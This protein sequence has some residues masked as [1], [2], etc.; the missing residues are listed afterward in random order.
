MYKGMYIALSGAMLKQTQLE[1]ITQNIANAN[2]TAYKKQGLSFRDYLLPRENA[3]S[4]PDGRIMVTLSQFATDFSNGTQVRT[5]NPFDIAL[6][7]KGMI[8][9]EGNRYTRRGDLMKD[10]EGYLT[11]K[12]GSKV[13]GGGGPIRIPESETGGQVQ[14]DPDGNIEVDGTQVDKIRIEEF[15][16]PEALTRAGDGAYASAAPGTPAA[17]V[18][19]QGYLETSNVSAVTEMIHMIEAMRE[20]ES[21]QKMIQAMDEAAAKVNNDLGRL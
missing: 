17:G 15:A 4:G 2:T 9:L 1:V 6:S 19:M 14:I 7:G 10:Q 16:A 3:P 12:D 13:L 21:Y 8:A 20:F 18:V 5:G 11:T